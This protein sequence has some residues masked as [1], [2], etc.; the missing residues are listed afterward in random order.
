MKI[1]LQK[2]IFI[3]EKGYIIE[4]VRP[5]YQKLMQKGELNYEISAFFPLAGHVMEFDEPNDT[6][7]S[8]AKVPYLPQNI[9]DYDWDKIA[10]KS[11]EKLYR[12]SKRTMGGR[13]GS[14]RVKAIR[15]FLKNNHVDFVIS[16]G[17][18]DREGTLLVLEVLNYLNIPVNTTK[19]FWIKGGFTD[20]KT[21]DALQNLLP[22]DYEFSDGNK[23]SNM[24]RA[25]ELRSQIDR[26]MGYSY[27]PALSLKTGAHI[28]FGRIKGPVIN[29]VVIRDLEIKNFKPQTYYTVTADF[30][31]GNKKYTGKLIDDEQREKSINNKAEADKIVQAMQNNPNSQVVLTEQKEHA[32]RPPQFLNTND[33]KKQFLKH[34]SPKA[35]EDA[36][37]NLY[38]KHKIMT[39]PR[40]DTRYVSKDD[41]STFNS[42]IKAAASIPNLVPFIKQLKQAN[43]DK[44]AKD[45]RYVDDKKAGAHEALVPTDKKF[46]YSKLTEL[47]QKIISYVDGYFIQVFLPDQIMLKSKI[48]TQNGKYQFL[49]NGQ[50]EKDPGWSVLFKKKT[51]A[52][53]LPPVNK[54]DQVMLSKVD[55]NKGITTPPSHYT[56]SSLIAAMGNVASLVDD[57]D[58]KKVL[59]ET[60]GLGTDTSQTNIVMGLIQS[61]QF[62]L[63]GKTIYASKGSIELIDA[64]SGLDIIDPISTADFETKLDDVQ[65]GKLAASDYQKQAFDYVSKQCAIIKNS[66]TIPILETR[67][68]GKDTG[69][70]FNQQKITLRKGKYGMYYTVLLNTGKNCFVS[71]SWRGM[72]IDVNTLKQML[73]GQLVKLTSPTNAVYDFKF[74]PDKGFSV[75]EENAQ[76]SLTYKNRAVTKHNG[77]FG[78]YYQ[79]PVTPKKSM[80]I[81]INLGGERG[82]KLT[83]ADLKTLLDGG[84]LKQKEVQFKSGKYNVDLKIDFKKYKLVPIF[85]DNNDGTDTGLSVGKDKL[86]MRKGKYGEY[87]HLG[88]YNLGKKW[89]SH[90]FTPEEAQKLFSGEKVHV[91]FTSKAGKKMETDLVYDKNKGKVTFAE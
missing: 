5:V 13:T 31:D 22:F 26:V 15:D 70:E 38:H 77:K 65:K 59:R 16:A 23:I 34:Y 85:N 20:S 52:K 76:T 58:A 25:S 8:W 11:G 3:A 41:A 43:I 53:I 29:M 62:L 9:V 71:E 45:K 69:L 4:N 60:K 17:D 37:E 33:V 87:Y 63:K 84:V 55:E 86:L 54:G 28:R 50:V 83:E 47:E 44:I 21:K 81:S 78:P 6:D 88:K 19:R 73:T 40:T 68:A 42:L 14:Q 30:N 27:S 49:T 89:S 35:I 24:Y 57:K 7:F 32:V 56:L 36:M 51:A 18:S 10:P 66:K 82:Y 46:D 39:Y 64:L 1:I 61:G 90:M 12:P 91:K 74:D 67:D 79:I 75:K 2:A 48:I 72:T 80:F